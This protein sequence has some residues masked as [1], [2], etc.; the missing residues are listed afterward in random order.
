MSVRAVAV[1]GV[2][3]RRLRVMPRV[4]SPRRSRPRASL[5]A[6]LADDRDLIGVKML[7]I[8]GL[9]FVMMLLEVP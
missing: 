3:S 1:R 9:L 4:L 2:P 8:A 5:W 7:M 6:R